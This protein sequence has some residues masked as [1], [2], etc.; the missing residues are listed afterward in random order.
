MP[1]SVPEMVEPAARVGLVIVSHSSLIAEG[2]AQVVREMAPDVSVIPAGGAPDGGIGTDFE[3]IGSA[4]DSAEAG[5]GVL[6]LCDL[7]SAIMTAES[8]IDFLDDRRR[9]RT[10]IA[11]APLV[12][13]AVAAGVAAQIGDD[14]ARVRSRAESA[15]AAAGPADG[16]DTHPARY[17]RTV[18]LVN[19]DGLHARPAADFVRLAGTFDAKVTVNGKDAK[20]LLGIMSLGLH[21]GTS[22]EIAGDEAAAQAV[23][24]LAALVESG[25]GEPSS[26]QPH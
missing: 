26:A 11:D 19:A 16:P 7:G 2:V 1:L 14:L 5:A 12:E 17:S 23:D 6:V 9:S 18:T 15:G 10:V 3:R 24:A 4:I 25:F 21:R 20:S 22:V 13:G 8:A